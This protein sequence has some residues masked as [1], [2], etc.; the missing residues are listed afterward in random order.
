MTS[1]THNKRRRK[2]LR[3]EIRFLLILIFMMIILYA[4]KTFY[5]VDSANVGV[6]NF[7]FIQFL[8]FGVLSYKLG[9]ICKER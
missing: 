6:D 8:G 5:F 1:R 7:R 2:R 4:S 3:G 9:T